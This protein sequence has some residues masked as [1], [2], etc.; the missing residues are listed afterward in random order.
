MSVVLS[1]R[2]NSVRVWPIGGVE[3]VHPWLKRSETTTWSTV[4]G[5]LHDDTVKSPI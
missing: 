3:M 4:S 2:T 1:D 5:L